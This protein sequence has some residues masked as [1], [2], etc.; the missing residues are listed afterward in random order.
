MERKRGKRKNKTMRKR[1]FKT[2]HCMWQGG[3]YQQIHILRV[4]AGRSKALMEREIRHATENRDYWSH[5][6]A[7]CWD[8][9]DWPADELIYMYYNYF[10]WNEIWRT[11]FE[12]E[13]WSFVSPFHIIVNAYLMNVNNGWLS[14]RREQQVCL[15]VVFLIHTS[16]LDISAKFIFLAPG[17]I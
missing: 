13:L 8:N 16:L 6:V 2:T 15:I 7:T 4:I 12:F 3:C 17:A 1:N 10:C 14:R 11:H 9:P 5:L